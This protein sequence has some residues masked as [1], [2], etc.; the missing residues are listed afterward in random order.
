MGPITSETARK[1]GLVVAAEA[2]EAT[3]DSLVE[4]VLEL[5]Q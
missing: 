3:I 5:A 4:A 1:L 2:R